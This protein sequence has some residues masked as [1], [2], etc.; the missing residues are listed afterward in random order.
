M[1]SNV[2]MW[3]CLILSAQYNLTGNHEGMAIFWLVLAGINLV[4]Y[5]ASSF[6]G[7]K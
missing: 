3:G 4:L 6:G 5:L 1:N 7:P 2:S